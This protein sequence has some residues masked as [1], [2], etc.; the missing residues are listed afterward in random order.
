ML[1]YVV[2]DL[3]QFVS[4]VLPALVLLYHA[5]KWY[6]EVIF[7][8]RYEPPS[9][10]LL[11]YGGVISICFLC[12][13]IV[14][15]FGSARLC[16]TN[17]TPMD[18]VRDGVTLCAV[19]AATVRITYGS[20]IACFCYYSIASFYRIILGYRTALTTGQIAWKYIFVFGY[21][22]L[23]A[24][25]GVV[26]GAYRFALGYQGCD[27]TVPNS[28]D[29]IVC[30]LPWFLFLVA[31][32]VCLSTICGKIVYLTYKGELDTFIVA[33]KLIG[34]PLKFMFLMGGFLFASVAAA[35]F[36]QTDQEIRVGRA[37][38]WGRCVIQHYDGATSASY[39]D[40]CG[41]HPDRIFGPVT[42]MTL[43][44][45]GTAGL[46]V[47]Y[48]LLF[49]QVGYLCNCSSPSAKVVPGE[50][51]VTTSRDTIPL[52][53]LPFSFKLVGAAQAPCVPIPT[54]IDALGSN[55]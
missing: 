17:A 22:L 29:F 7:R 20:C 40:I 37:E 51:P 50:L 24:I 31:G 36:M 11:V 52:N 15:S 4:L 48:V 28:I 14:A 45:F 5:W 43:V 21:P 46:S 54:H 8:K 1:L 18:G 41:K 42:L 13:S 25:I 16:S 19:E 23:A 2:H 9:A 30:Q 53:A 39:V 47:T 6:S 33:A 12:L 44:T 34:T 27:V 35:L 26:S 49:F 10:L 3:T 32:M 38:E 55:S